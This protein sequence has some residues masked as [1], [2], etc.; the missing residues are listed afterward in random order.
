MRQNDTPKKVR[1]S[2]KPTTAQESPLLLI[3]EAASILRYHPKYLCELIRSKRIGAH[4][5]GRKWLVPKS[6]I[7]RFLGKL[8]T[9]NTSN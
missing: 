2:A 9:A 1:N 8:N 4:R 6:E 5:A 3:S 7:D